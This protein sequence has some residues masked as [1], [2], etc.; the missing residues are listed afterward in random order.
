M[1]ESLIYHM[2]RCSEWRSAEALGHYDGSAQDK[3]D[4]FIH[5]STAA[6]LA[7][8]AAKHRAG[9]TDLVLLAVWPDILGPPLKWEP[10]RGG[11]LFPHLYGLL[12]VAAVA[13]VADLPL[14]PDGRHRFPPLD[15]P[16][17]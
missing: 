17:R 15:A 6:H 9:Q 10:A 14:G 2:C 1:A 7:D 5:F 13:W 11:I 16:A 12:P 3:S 8:S 4:G